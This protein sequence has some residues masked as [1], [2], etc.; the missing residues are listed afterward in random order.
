MTGVIEQLQQLGFSQ[1]EAQAY[2]TLL[3]NGPANGYELA[4]RSG[5]P[6]PSIYPV[7]QKLEERGAIRRVE[8]LDGSRYAPVPAQE[9][10]LKLNNQLHQAIE[11]ASD[12]LSN[13]VSPPIIDYT[14]NFRGYNDLLAYSQKML[15]TARRQV[16]VALWP[17]EAS[18]LAEPLQR[19]N[20]RGVHL[21]TLCLNACEH[22]CPFCQGSI[23]RYQLAPTQKS[24]WLVL[25]SDLDEMLAGE[26]EPGGD[27]LAVCTHQK[28]LVSLTAGY[29]RNSIALAKILTGLGGLFDN[30][31]DPETQA[32]LDHLQEQDHW[33]DTMRGLIHAGEDRGNKE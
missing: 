15:E 6:R 26:I 29:I 13:I 32:D 19:A 2:V 12:S 1:Y 25:V 30:L 20:E 21:V 16:L 14:Q 8:T 23:F 24:R 28:M 7:M 3:M 5:I 10:I 17:E 22:P 31:L 18:A 11:A 33:L 4:K 27:S 9:L